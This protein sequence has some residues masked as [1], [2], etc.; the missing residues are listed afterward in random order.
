MF[1]EPGKLIKE[2]ARILFVFL[3]ALNIILSGF[4][5]Y[6]S[7]KLDLGEAGVLVLIYGII[8]I[9]FGTLVIWVLCLLT[10]GFGELIDDTE[11]I[12]QTTEDLYNLI[13]REK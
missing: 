2:V 9:I 5:I 3:T 11:D 4:A 6:M 8:G 12:R 7:F 1:D 13:G 10:Y